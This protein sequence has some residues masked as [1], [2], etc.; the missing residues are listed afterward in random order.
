[1]FNAT[2]G[3]SRGFAPAGIEHLLALEELCAGIGCAGAQESDKTSIESA[4]RS[5]ITMHPSHPRVG[6][7]FGGNYHFYCED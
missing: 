4:F 3:Q 2:R 6:I 7:N 5:A 1:M